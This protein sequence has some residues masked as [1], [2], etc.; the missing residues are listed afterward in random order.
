MILLDLFTFLGHLHPVVVHLPLGFL[1]LAFIFHL[2]AGRKKLNH[3]QQAVPFILLAGF[4]SAILAC[5]FGYILSLS[6]DYDRQLLRHHK[7]SGI[8]LTVFS[9]ILC[10]A[11]FGNFF[12]M[13]R[14]IFTICFA[15]LIGLITYSGHNGGSLTH[16]REYLTLKTLTHQKR[17]KPANLDEAY[18]FEDVIQP[19]LQAKCAQCHAG[20]KLKG[21]LSVESLA[22]LLKG[23]KSGAA[24]VAG[25]SLE[26]EL[27][28]RITL[29]ASDE[30]FMP[31]DGKPPLKKNEIEIIRWWIEKANATEVQK[32]VS[33]KNNDSIAAKV[34][35]YLGLTMDEA[36]DEEML[37]Q[38]I[39][40]AIPESLDTNA[41]NNL[42]KKGWMLRWML[43]K[44]AMLDVT[45]PLTGQSTI[46]EAVPD[47]EKLAKNIIWLNLSENNLSDSDLS[48][49]SSLINLEKLRIEKNPVTDAVCDQ[50]KSLPH[51]EAVNLNETKIT[52][53]GIETLRTNAAI[54]RVYTNLPA[55]PDP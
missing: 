1:L 13:S 4:I 6:G 3:L 44:P 48:F 18:I 39:N 34:S 19:M 24:V 11:T 27:Y 47:L 49:L 40:P 8:W 30:K 26:S 32:F 54:R 17:K 51:L 42:R 25:N 10:V 36:E 16:G 21:K 41:V 9:G 46:K 28:K 2:L 23:G 22:D 55:S 29:P 52:V 53:K 31:S 12:K 43:Q 14:S 37:L 20:G 15:I 35:A 5:I 33:I 38:H 50:L 7:W 45:R